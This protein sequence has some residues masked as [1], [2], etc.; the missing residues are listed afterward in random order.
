MTRSAEE[1]R[2]VLS[3]LT[4]N[5]NVMYIVGACEEIGSNLAFVR[6]LIIKT[7]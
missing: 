4:T 5:H 2:V 3:V 7:A 6:L 1:T